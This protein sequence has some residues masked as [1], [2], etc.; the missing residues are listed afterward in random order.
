MQGIRAGS[1]VVLRS[2]SGPANDRRRF[3]TPLFHWDTQLADWRKEREG[4][5][6]TDNK[7]QDQGSVPF[8]TFHMWSMGYG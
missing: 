3:L 7:T 6:F 8:L 5:S 4:G 2:C 1:N